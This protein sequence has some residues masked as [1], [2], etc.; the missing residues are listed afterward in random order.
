MK[1]GG[2]V[3]RGGDRHEGLAACKAARCDQ[4]RIVIR[5]GGLDLDEAASVFRLGSDNLLHASLH[6][7]LQL[8][9][10][11]VTLQGLVGE[12]VDHVLLQSREL[13]LEPGVSALQG[14]HLGLPVVRRDLVL[15]ILLGNHQALH[16]V[17]DARDRRVGHDIAGLQGHLHRIHG[18]DAAVELLGEVLVLVHLSPHVVGEVLLNLA[19][20]VLQHAGALGN[21]GRCVRGLVSISLQTSLQALPRRLQLLGEACDVVLAAQHLVPHG[22]AQLLTP[23]GHHLLHGAPVCRLA[24][25]E[26]RRG[27]LQALEARLHIADLHLQRN[28][29]GTALLQAG[30]QALR[31]FQV[32]VPLLLVAC[33]LRIHLVLHG[34]EGAVGLGALL[35]TQRPIRLHAVPGLHDQRIHLVDRDIAGGPLGADR[36]HQFIDF[37]LD[38]LQA[39]LT[40]LRLT[41]DRLFH[42]LARHGLLL[43]DVLALLGALVLDALELSGQGRNLLGHLCNLVHDHL[44]LELGQLLFLG[45]DLALLLLDLPQRGGGHRGL[46]GMPILLDGHC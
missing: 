12:A 10:D 15:E 30:I 20:P 19:A 24:R 36:L 3:R 8:G 34:G 37:H 2:A 41:G 21:G 4:A 33:A 1:G 22:L 32:P 23:A 7:V 6:R 18:G 44:P 29:G 26:G 13:T 28:V 45:L 16:D 43:L 11:A 46:Q 25:L 40:L 14:V 35:R 38:I 31:C 9:L 27:S 39:N 42:P 17:L 5:L